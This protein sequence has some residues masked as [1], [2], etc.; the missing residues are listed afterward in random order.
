MSIQ[1]SSCSYENVEK[2]LFDEKICYLEASL[3]GSSCAGS[4]EQFYWFIALILS[5]TSHIMPT[6]LAD[7]A[8]WT[9]YQI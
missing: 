3:S 4:V 5:I 8:I 6:Q 7:S 2:E 9:T 1:A